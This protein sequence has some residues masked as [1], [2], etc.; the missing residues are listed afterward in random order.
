[1]SLLSVLVVE[2]EG[3]ARLKLCRFL[4]RF[5][6]LIQV[7]EASD[8][9]E[10]LNICR[11]VMPQLV[12]VDIQ[13]PLI[14][15]ISLVEALVHEGS[16]LV[17]F[18]T[19]HEEYAIQ[20]FEINAVDYLLKPFSYERFCS[21]MIRVNERLSL[22]ST[23]D[24]DSCQEADSII[25]KENSPVGDYLTH[26]RVEGDMRTHHIIRLDE[27]L[28]IRAAG[29]YN[30][31]FTHGRAYLRRGTLK[32]LLDRLN[33]QVFMRI[34]RSEIIQIQEIGSV[35][36][37]GHGDAEITMKSGVRLRWSRRYRSQNGGRFEV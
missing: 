16:P 6:Q 14:D 28:F 37:E 5:S 2:D 22:I 12:I 26:I 23:S 21:T 15:G 25:P 8:G 10:G 18:T 1:M 20:A 19:A 13:M 24:H 31:F 11:E 32:E 34:N 36:V 17:V 33:P 30:E 4:K 3:H 29:N 27:V 9:V 35:S 7:H